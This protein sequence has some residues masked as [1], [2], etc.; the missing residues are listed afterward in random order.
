MDTECWVDIAAITKHLRK[1]KEIADKSM[2]VDFPPTSDIKS[3]I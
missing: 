2:F 3:I 1:S